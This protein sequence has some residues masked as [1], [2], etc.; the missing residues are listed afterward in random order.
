MDLEKEDQVF[1]EQ[2]D[3]SVPVDSTTAVQS[4]ISYPLDC[5][6]QVKKFYVYNVMQV[7]V[8]II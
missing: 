3:E 7:R 1:F 8:N 4:E 2:F 5:E 6:P